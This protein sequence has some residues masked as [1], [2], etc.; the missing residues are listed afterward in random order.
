VA[1]EDSV[2]LPPPSLGQIYSGLG[3]KEDAI[4]AARADTAAIPLRFDALVGME[5]LEDLALT[6]IGV[7]E[8]DLALDVIDTLLSIP[9]VLSVAWIKTSPDFDPLRDHPRF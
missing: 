1:G 3:R 4:L 2:S 6:Y 9:S 5:R 8:Y 7:A